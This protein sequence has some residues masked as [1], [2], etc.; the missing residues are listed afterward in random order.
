VRARDRGQIRLR[1]IGRGEGVGNSIP[2]LIIVSFTHVGLR[3]RC[4]AFAASRVRR[5]RTKPLRPAF[6]I[7]TDALP[8]IG[9]IA[10][11]PVVRVIDPRHVDDPSLSEQA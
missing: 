4:V 1:N 2:N 6:T 7:E 8:G 9:R 5:R 11:T 3:R 10:S